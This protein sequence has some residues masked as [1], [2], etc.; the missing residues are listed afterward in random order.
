MRLARVLWALGPAHFGHARCCS[1][2][3]R[4]SAT[5]HRSGTAA[6]VARPPTVAR[7]GSGDG[8]YGHACHNMFVAATAVLITKITACGGLQRDAR[9]QTCIC[10]GG[11]KSCSHSSHCLKSRACDIGTEKSPR[12]KYDT[13]A[14]KYNIQTTLQR[15]KLLKPRQ[16]NITTPSQ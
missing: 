1:G 9:S 13:G 11:C 16:M 5:V 15:L 2:C 4:S 7:W 12:A 10:N 8:S 14:E 3:F 6:A